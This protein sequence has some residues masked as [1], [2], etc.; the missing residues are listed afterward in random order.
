MVSCLGETAELL[1]ACFWGTEELI[2]G[3]IDDLRAPAIHPNRLMLI[4]DEQYDGRDRWNAVHGEYEWLPPRFDERQ[5]TDWVEASSQIDGRCVYVPAAYTYIGYS[6]GNDSFCLGDSNGCASGVSVEYAI[7]AGFLELVERDAC[8]IWWYGRHRRPALDL[9]NSEDPDLSA[10]MG[11]LARRDRTFH[12]LDLTTDLGI[13]VFAAVSAN[14]DGGTVALGF[15]AHFTA[16]KAALAAITEMLQLELSIAAYS[17]QSAKGS[18]PALHRWLHDVNFANNPQ[19]CPANKPR[20][21]LEAYGDPLLASPG[22][23][24]KQCIAVCKAQGL[25]L[26]TVD[27]TRAEIAVP[28]VRVLVPGLRHYRARFGSGRLYDVPLKLGWINHPMNHEMINPT[29]LLI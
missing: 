17:S 22:S 21:P 27:L 15:G 5:K 24:L 16:T 3:Q 11:W 23:W 20:R 6:G 19:L 9:T 13:T 8:A 12:L 14:S 10:L 25:Q 29:P 1:S 2:L 4:S 28:V 18:N 7:A 26:L